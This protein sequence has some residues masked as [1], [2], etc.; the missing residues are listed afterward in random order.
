MGENVKR[1]RNAADLTQE[2]L[3]ERTGRTQQY[4]S[5][6]ENGRR[7]PTIIVLFEIAQVLGVTPAELLTPQKPGYRA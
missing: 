3:A 1:A 7:N 6:L 4:I 2:V 5:G